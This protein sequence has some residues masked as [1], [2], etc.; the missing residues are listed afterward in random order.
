VTGRK[1]AVSRVVQ[2]VAHYLGNTPAVARRSYIDPR[3][4]SLYADG[5]T[6]SP[7]LKLLGSEAE[8]GEMATS[9]KVETA[10]RR[11]LY[12]HSRAGGK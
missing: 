7:A 8:P 4:I 9:G 10:V 5:I 12:N 11:M 6:V 3:V 1:R 2:E